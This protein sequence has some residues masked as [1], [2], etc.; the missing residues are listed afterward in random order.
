MNSQ[1]LSVATEG[2]QTCPWESKE[3][4]GLGGQGFSNSHQVLD[5]SLSDW[6]DLESKSYIKIWKVSEYFTGKKNFLS[7][8]FNFPS[9]L[10]ILKTHPLKS[11]F[12]WNEMR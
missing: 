8:H 9:V 5:G 11:L 4:G 10:C 6:C 2:S 1:E 7:E 12:E 3:C